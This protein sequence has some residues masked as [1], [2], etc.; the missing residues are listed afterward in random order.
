[1]TGLKYSYFGCDICQNTCP[2]N[3][4]LKNKTLPS[5]IEIK[6]FPSLYEIAIMNSSQYE[7]YFGG[8]PMTRAK[9]NGLRRNALIAMTVLKDPLLSSAIEISKLDCEHPIHATLCQI[10]Q[11]LTTNS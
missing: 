9:R 7:K 10:E 1:M 8:T 6:K 2:L 3:I 11:Y 4:K 5:D